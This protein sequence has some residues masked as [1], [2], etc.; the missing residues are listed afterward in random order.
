MATI[1]ID[2]GIK[3]ILGLG[4]FAANKAVAIMKEEASVRDDGTPTQGKG[5]NALVNSIKYEHRLF[6]NEYAIG[7]HVE[8]AEHFRYGRGPVTPKGKKNGGA[9]VLH[10]RDPKFGD[11]FTKH[12]GPAPPNHFIERTIAR[13]EAEHFN[14]SDV[15]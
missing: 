6:S 1:T 4:M 13:L 2:Q 14:I 10:W 11:V 8:Y 12:A 7:P 3:G 9:D 15:T 5:D